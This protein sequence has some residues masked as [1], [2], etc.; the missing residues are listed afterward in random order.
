LVMIWCRVV[1]DPKQ[2]GAK[3]IDRWNYWNQLASYARDP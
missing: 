3:D 2:L 1:A